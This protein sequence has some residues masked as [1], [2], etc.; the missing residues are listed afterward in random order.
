[1]AWTQADVDALERSIAKGLGAGA[2]TFADQSVTFASLEDRLE[3]LATMRR[4]VAGTTTSPTRYAA[5][6]KGV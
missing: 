1:M 5:T 6:D 2:M 4:T 3:L